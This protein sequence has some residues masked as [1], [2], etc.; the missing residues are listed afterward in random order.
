MLADFMINEGL[1]GVVQS[2]SN[3]VEDTPD[4][5]LKSVSRVSNSDLESENKV[6]IH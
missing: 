2:A 3:S 1:S 5:A 4:E 6:T